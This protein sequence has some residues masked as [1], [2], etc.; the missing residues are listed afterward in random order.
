MGVAGIIRA[1]TA[2]RSA[3]GLFYPG[4]TRY[5]GDNVSH[6]AAHKQLFKLEQPAD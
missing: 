3:A 1:F 2:G 6:A 5:Y 4:R